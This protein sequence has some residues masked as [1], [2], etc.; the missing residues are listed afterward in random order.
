MCSQAY[1]A[2]YIYLVSEITIFSTVTGQSVT[3]IGRIP[4]LRPARVKYLLAIFADY[5]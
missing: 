3:K 2:M 1:L 5:K 4:L